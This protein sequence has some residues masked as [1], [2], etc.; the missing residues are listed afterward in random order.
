MLNEFRNFLTFWLGT[1]SFFGIS[2]ESVSGQ[3]LPQ[4][5]PSSI[6]GYPWHKNQTKRIRS[7]CYRGNNFQDST[8]REKQQKIKHGLSPKKCFSLTP[9]S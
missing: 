1:G 7:G 8:K 2:T 4:I 6:R 3:Q 9:F 5:V